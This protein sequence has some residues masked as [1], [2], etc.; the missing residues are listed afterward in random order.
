MNFVI[1]WILVF[2]LIF[3]VGVICAIRENRRMRKGRPSRYPESHIVI[4]QRIHRRQDK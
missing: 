3:A 2:L 4:G 1:V